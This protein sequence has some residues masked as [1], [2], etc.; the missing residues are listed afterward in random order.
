VTARA[1][2][3]PA[4]VSRILGAH[5]DS[6]A[7]VEW[8]SG[9][10]RND[11]TGQP[12]ALL[13]NCLS[14][15][16]QAPECNGM[17]AFDEFASSIVFRRDAPWGARKGT[18]WADNDDRLLTELLQS[19]SINVGVEVASQAAQTIARE[20]TFHPLRD[21]LSSLQWDRTARIGA[22]LRDYLGAKDS[23]YSRAV[24]ERWLISGVARAFQ[25]GAKAD[26]CLIFEGPQGR[27]KSTAFR[28]LGEPY[29]TDEL[30]DFGTKDACL[31]MLGAWIV[32]IAELDSMSRSEVSRTK[33]F[34][35]RTIDRFR[36]PY[37]RNVIEAPRQCIFAG[38]VNHST[39]LRD[40]TGA[41]RFWPIECGQIDI[42]R[43]REDRNQLWAE[44]T[45]RYHSGANWWLDSE[46]LVE[47]AAA[48]Q[49]NRYEG[50]PWDDLISRW[51]SIKSDVSIP[52]ILEVCL[53]KPQSSW[54]QIDRNRVA[55]CLRSLGWER[56]NAR[57]GSS[58]TG[59]E[60]RYRLPN[61]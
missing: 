58:V 44:A 56:Y 47:A 43:L 28:V 21:W 12:R 53:N 9:L 39:Y 8:R 52:E 27:F 54:Q 38:T 37:G 15:L 1:F 16:R 17:L 4:D 31:Q 32:E 50:D 42:H 19:E 5:R 57:T 46:A 24:G 6:R 34:M 3:M 48:E 11:R 49:A 2:T 35:S 61:E 20:H 22:W 23:D 40:E 33:G 30:S 10:V 14:A 18:R 25:P 41:R 55:R 51:V 45:Q 7:N 36:P 13:L 29:F 60:W 26:C 59:R